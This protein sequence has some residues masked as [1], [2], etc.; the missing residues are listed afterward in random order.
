M[1]PQ[2]RNALFTQFV[3]YQKRQTAQLNSAGSLGAQQRNALF[4][5]FLAYQ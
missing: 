1:S 5:E 2:A 4:T 3:A